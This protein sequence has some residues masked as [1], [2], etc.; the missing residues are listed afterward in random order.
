MILDEDECVSGLM[1]KHIIEGKGLPVFFYGQTYGFSL[2]ETT[3]ISV[4]YLLFGI[5]D[6]NVKM[7]MLCLFILGV[8]FFFKTLKVIGSN[9]WLALLITMMLIFSPSWAVW[10]MKA[11]GG[12]LTAFFLSSMVTWLLFNKK[13]SMPANWLLIGILLGIIAYSQPLWL[14]GLLMFV[15]FKIG[16]NSKPKLVSLLSGLLPIMLLIEL[17]RLG[18]YHMWNPRVFNLVPDLSKAYFLLFHHLTGFYYLDHIFPPPVICELFAAM[19]I[20]LLLM[21]IVAA[22][23]Y[24]IKGFHKYKLY[25]V[26]IAAILA[27]LCYSLF[28]SSSSPRY[29]LPLTGYGLLTLYL[30]SESFTLPRTVSLISLL[31]IVIGS[32]AMDSFQHYIYNPYTKTQLMSC[33][34]TLEQKDLNY[35]F[36]NDVPQEWQ[37]MFYSKEKIICR[38][39]DNA[40]RYPGYVKKVNEVYR[41]S[42]KNTAVVDFSGDIRDMAPDQVFMAG[43]IFYIMPAPD[44]QFLSDMDVKF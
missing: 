30:F 15:L 4:F 32:Y 17:I 9:N 12:Y 40:D 31:F 19:F 35:I 26:S 2:L 8:V 39:S 13:S 22:L 36:C 42:R 1:A 21:L 6:Y 38:A 5:S 10:S 29:L 20:G 25:I 16:N 3:F 44:E 41:R 33:I 11:R 27:T 7:A 37:L 14:P 43:D 18:T 34:R 23:V 24:A 28:L